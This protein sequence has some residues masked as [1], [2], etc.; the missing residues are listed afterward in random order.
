[1]DLTLGADGWLRW[2]GGEARTAIGRSGR[3]VAEAKRE[4]DGAT[5]IGAWPLRRL[6]W[7]ADRLVRPPTR[8]DTVTVSPDDGWCDAPGNPAYNQ[9]VKHPYRAGAER[10][11]RAD[12]LYDMLVVLG[13]NDAPTLAGRGSAIFLH[14]ASSDYRPTEGC[15]AAALPDLLRML[16]GAGPEDRLIIG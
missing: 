10:L 12:H 3:R 16:A 9:A 14:V 7:R 15:V 13:F 6:L 1:M 2:P 8:L 11:W 5:P 4:G